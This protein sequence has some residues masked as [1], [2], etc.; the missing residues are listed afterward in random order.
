MN[1]LKTLRFYVIL[2]YR[3]GLFDRDL[4]EY[5]WEACTCQE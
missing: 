3:M 5:L 2:G 1:R 4:F